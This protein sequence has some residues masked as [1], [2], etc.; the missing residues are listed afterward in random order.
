MITD[1]QLSLA[2]RLV[3]EPQL[4]GIGKDGLR[5]ITLPLS[6]IVEAVRE[7][8]QGDPFF[9]PNAK[10]S[11]LGDGAV[12]ERRGKHL[13]RVHERYE[14]GQLR[15]SRISSRLSFSLRGATKRYLH[16]YRS[17]LRAYGVTIGWWA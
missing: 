16:H 12:I 14:V 4:A 2:R 10:P 13:F 1:E 15:Y 8:L 17:L 11:E 3:H 9:P 7:S 6:A 5:D